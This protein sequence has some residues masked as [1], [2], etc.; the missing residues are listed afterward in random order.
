M[1]AAVTAQDRFARRVNMDVASHTA[2]MDPILPELRVGT[3]R[4]DPQDARRSHSFPPSSRPRRPVL[5]ADYWVANVRQP[6]RFSQAVTAAGDRPRHLRRDQCRTRLLAHAITETLGEPD[7]H[8]VG[9][10]SRDADDTISFHTNLNTTHTTHPPQTPH[11]PEPAPGAT[12]HPL[13]P[14]QPLDHR[15]ARATGP[16]QAEG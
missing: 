8:S 10:L 13:A 4:S 5:D 3:G 14:H 15:P 2:L 11:P 6:V 1:I 9:T 12:R 7:H 16:G